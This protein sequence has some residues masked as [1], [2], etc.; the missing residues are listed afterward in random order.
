MIYTWQNGENWWQCAP[1]RPNRHRD[2]WE[3]SNVKIM[4]QQANRILVA[5]HCIQSRLT[6]RHLTFVVKLALWF[7][8]EFLYCGSVTQ[9]NQL[10]IFESRR[11]SEIIG[12]N[13]F[14]YSIMADVTSGKC[15]VF[16]FSLRRSYL[17]NF[18]FAFTPTIILETKFHFHR[19]PVHFPSIPLFIAMR[20]FSPNFNRIKSNQ[21]EW[22][23][24]K[25]VRKSNHSAIV[26]QICWDRLES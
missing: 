22:K 14:D 5:D 17:E 3:N 9:R 7:F 12:W 25:R 16:S 6:Y 19:Q 13:N 20:R 18:N 21:I 11:F 24:S 1:N 8:N 26:N 10:Y 2:E 15:V 23:M 4:A